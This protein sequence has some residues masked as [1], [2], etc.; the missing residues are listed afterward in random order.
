MAVCLKTLALA[1]SPHLGLS[2]GLG[3]ALRVDA[4]A[5]ATSLQT[6]H[7]QTEQTEPATTYSNIF[8]VAAKCAES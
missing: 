8:T 6:K 7:R 4:L 3:L 2:I 1:W 5:L